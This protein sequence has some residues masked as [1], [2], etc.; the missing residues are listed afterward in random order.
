MILKSYLEFLFGRN[1]RHVIL[2]FVA[3]DACM[4]LYKIAG[5]YACFHSLLAYTVNDASIEGAGKCVR[6]QL[7]IYSSLVCSH[8]VRSIFI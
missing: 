2:H 4:A 8:R 5:T 7:H 6:V 3:V 1:Y